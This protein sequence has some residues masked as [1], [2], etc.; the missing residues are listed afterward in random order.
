LALIS[1]VGSD[2]LMFFN[3]TPPELRQ[4]VIQANYV[5][6]FDFA[7]VALE[8]M[9]PCN[10]GAI[11]SISSDARRQGEP[12][13][14]VHGGMKAAINRFMKIA[15]ENGRNGLR[16]NVVL[17][18]LTLPEAES[19]VGGISLWHDPTGMFKPEQLKESHRR[20]ACTGSAARTT[21]RTPSRPSPPRSPPAT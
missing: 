11:V 19:D 2:E 16:C 4:K 14:A 21:S 15:K 3:Q 13:E 6:V 20:S 9:S 10:A 8:T 18:G 12:R 17:A 7:R 5:D 1:N